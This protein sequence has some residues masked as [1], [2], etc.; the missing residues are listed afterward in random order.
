MASA[1]TTT[2]RSPAGLIRLSGI[3][4]VVAGAV[5]LIG[6]AVT[7]FTVSGQLADEKI[8]V[9]ADADSFAGEKI[10]GPFTAYAEAQVIEKHAL[11]AS[12]GKTYAELPKDDPK[13]EVVMTGSFL[14]SSLFT[15]VVSFG[16]AAMAMG[17]GVL[18]AIIGYALLQLAR[19]LP[20]PPVAGTAA[21]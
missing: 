4:L 10:D 9:S 14:R 5:M 6:G 8:T 18:V 11:A 15:S 20:A 21:D 12:G 3:L 7:W 16:V 13:R 17:L 19:Y 1:R 2:S